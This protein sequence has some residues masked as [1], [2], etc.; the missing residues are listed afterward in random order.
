MLSNVMILTMW[1]KWV[2]NNL[3]K[4]AKDVFNWKKPYIDFISKKHFTLILRIK[5][6]KTI[7]INCTGKFCYWHG[8]FRNTAAAGSGVLKNFTKIRERHMCHYL[9]LQNH[10]G[11]CFW[12]LVYMATQNVLREV[13]F[14]G[15]VWIIHRAAYFRGLTAFGKLMC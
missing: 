6:I 4:V 9:I 8:H 13:R 15:I 14:Y 3:Q 1:P 10:S 7:I 11:G 5:L 12:E 2:Y